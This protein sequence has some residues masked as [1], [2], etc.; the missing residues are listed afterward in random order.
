MSKIPL[1]DPSRVLIVAFEGWNDAGDAATTAAQTLLDQRVHVV[2]SQIDPEEYFDFQLTRPLVEH[3]TDGSRFLNW[4][5]VTLYGPE[6][7]DDETPF[8]LL[9]QEPSRLWR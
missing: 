1:S 5:D 2:L 9:G 3:A 8:V 4:P 7:G 6:P